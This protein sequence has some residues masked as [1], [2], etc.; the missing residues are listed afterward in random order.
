VLRNLNSYSFASCRLF[1]RDIWYNLAQYLDLIRIHDKIFVLTLHLTVSA[2]LQCKLLYTVVMTRKTVIS[3]TK[4]VRVILLHMKRV[5]LFRFPEHARCPRIS[6]HLQAFL[7]MKLPCARC[8]ENWHTVSCVRL[9][10]LPPSCAVVMKSGNLKFL[11]PSGPL[12]ACNGAALPYIY[13]VH[14]VLLVYSQCI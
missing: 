1:V 12:Q 5:F 8:R 9:T 10:T 3:R 7:T 4:S 6:W 2:S 11:E 14:C 13:K